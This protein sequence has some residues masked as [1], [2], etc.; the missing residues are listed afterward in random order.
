MMSL[1][2]STV[3]AIQEFVVLSK[4]NHVSFENREKTMQDLR[5]EARTA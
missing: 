3:Q 4:D 5:A 2:L 1:Q